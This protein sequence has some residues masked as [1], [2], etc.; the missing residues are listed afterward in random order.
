MNHPSKFTPV[1]ISSFVM[2]FLSIFPVLNLINVICCAG[3]IIGGASGT[4]YYARQLE[5]SGQFIQNKDGVMIGLLAGIISA[6]VYVIFST[7]IIMLAKQNPVEMVYK[8][9]EQWGFNIP[10]ESERILRTV[11]DEYSRNGFSTIMIG[12]ELFSRIV[13]HC[14]FGAAGGLLAASIFNKRRNKFQQ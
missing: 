11:N 1:I 12:V 6:I 7:T 13:S 2:V 10:P 4:W 9:T 5:K 3:I 8:M 14:I